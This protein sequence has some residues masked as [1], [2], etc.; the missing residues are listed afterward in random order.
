MFLPQS[1][2]SNLTDGS[3]AAVEPGRTG[4]AG[5]G[6]PFKSENIIPARVG[7]EFSTGAVMSSVPARRAACARPFVAT[8]RCE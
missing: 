1:S 4:N 3:S 7:C 8:Y 6:L 5:M 2:S